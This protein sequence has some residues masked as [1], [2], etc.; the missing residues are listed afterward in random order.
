[1]KV[2]V[3]KD[4]VANLEIGMVA[5]EGVEGP[6]RGRVCACGVGSN[7]GVQVKECEF[8]LV[9]ARSH[10]AEMNAKRATVLGWI[11]RA[12]IQGAHVVEKTHP[13]LRRIDARVDECR[14]Q[15]LQA[16]VAAGQVPEVERISQIL[17]QVA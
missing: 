16:A 17:R 7:P 2:V 8:F 11:F 10:F 5:M 15:D 12:Q 13:T 3:A 6:D 1:M 4:R 14:H 9:R